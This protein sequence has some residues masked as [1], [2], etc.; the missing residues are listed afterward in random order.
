LNAL[1]IVTEIGKPTLFITGTVNV[2]WPEIQSRLLKGQ[3]AFDR[4][5]DCNNL[6]AGIQQLRNMCNSEMSNKK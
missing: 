3:T 2:N 6:L 4:P 1:T 5:I